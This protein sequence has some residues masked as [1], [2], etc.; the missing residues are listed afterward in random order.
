MFL[1]ENAW[2]NSLHPCSVV[3][4]FWV[5]RDCLL[6]MLGIVEVLVTV[7]V[8]GGGEVDVD[9][10][11]TSGTAGCWD[12]WESGSFTGWMASIGVISIK[13]WKKLN[14]GKKTKMGTALST[15]DNCKV[16]NCENQYW[17][18]QHHVENSIADS[19]A[20][21]KACAKCLKT[22]YTSRFVRAILAQ[23]PCYLLCIVP[24]LSDDPRRK[25]PYIYI[26]TYKYICSCII[27]IVVIYII[28][29]DYTCI[30]IWYITCSIGGS[31]GLGARGGDHGP[32]QSKS[33]VVL[34]DLNYQYVKFGFIYVPIL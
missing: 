6:R 7:S 11:A 15:Y 3:A 22:C 18:M 20:K 19:V 27:D 32:G 31:Q 10:G 29:A 9:V 8:R 2:K 1:A 34:W 21:A 28:Y 24:I 4:Y 23:G 30:Y 13:L 26:H 17:G 16:R 33:P 14:E 25:N 12:S 5:G